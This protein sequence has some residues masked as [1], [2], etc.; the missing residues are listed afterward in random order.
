MKRKITP[1]G[2]SLIMIMMIMTFVSANLNWGKDRWKHIILTDGK[3]YYAYLPAIFIYHDLNFGFFDKIEKEKY[4]DKPNYYDYRS[5][6]YGKYIDKYY[7]GTTVAELPFFLSAHFVSYLLHFDQDGY[8]IVYCIF[9]TLAALFYLFIGLLFLNRILA[10]Y[11]IGEWERSLILFTSVFATHLFY[12]TVGEPSM[13]HVFSFAFTAMFFHY[14]KQYFASCQKR[15]IPCLGFLL[16][17]I[18]LIRPVNIMILFIWPFAAG[19]FSALKDGVASAFRHDDVGCC[20]AWSYLPGY[21]CPV[22]LFI[23]Y[24]PVI[25]LSIV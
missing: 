21:I 25:S 3:G 1:S 15:L 4:Y 18:F 14:S 5:W 11:G 24:L 22:F 12:Y 19:S 9:I 2:I 8:S 6:A 7:A 13:S 16:G 17:I 23:E 10:G 20:T